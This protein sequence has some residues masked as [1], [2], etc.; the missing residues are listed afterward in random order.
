[1]IIRKYF[2]IPE[3]TTRIFIKLLKCPIDFE[4][5]DGQPINPG[6]CLYKHGS[7]IESMHMFGKVI[8]L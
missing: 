2:S 5:A 1:M 7:K 8:I 6:Y 3:K 4:E